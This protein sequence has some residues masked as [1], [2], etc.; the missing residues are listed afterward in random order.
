MVIGKKVH[1]LPWA[2]T[3]HSR[4]MAIEVVVFVYGSVESFVGTL[5]GLCPVHP[6]ALHFV[7]GFVRVPSWYLE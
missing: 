3:L 7:F 4:A 5:S 6:L 1:V 2:V